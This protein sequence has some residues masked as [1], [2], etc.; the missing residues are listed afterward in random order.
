[1]CHINEND[2]VFYA[3]TYGTSVDQ[4]NYITFYDIEKC[5]TLK[6]IKIP[7]D[8]DLYG[9]ILVNKDYLIISKSQEKC[10]LIDVT[11]R[12]IINDLEYE[13]Y[14][15]YFIYLNEKKFLIYCGGFID[16][17]EFEK[18]ESIK[19]V[20]EKKI[21]NDLISKYPGNKL[22]IYSRKKISIYG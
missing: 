7:Y 2:Y 1:M 9:M 21:K 19:L 5:K 11:K 22:I 13:I 15:D 8:V 17:Y 20:E 10:T 3:N 12:E 4:D 16:Q 14:F 6:K 18:S